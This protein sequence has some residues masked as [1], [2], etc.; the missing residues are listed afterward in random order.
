MQTGE[1]GLQRWGDTP[2]PLTQL[3]GQDSARPLPW[4]LPWVPWGLRHVNWSPSTAPSW[5]T[6][7]VS[8]QDGEQRGDVLK[9]HPRRAPGA[10]GPD[11]GS[12]GWQEGT[13]TGE[14]APCPEV[15]LV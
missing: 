3:W 6:I 11:L 12:V 9:A 7:S 15:V 4:V 14:R 13:A 8:P 10:W 2:T 5:G 1:L